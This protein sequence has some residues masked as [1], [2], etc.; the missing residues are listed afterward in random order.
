LF[1]EDDYELQDEENEEPN[2]LI[3]QVEV[4]KVSLQ[5]D[6][7]MSQSLNIFMNSLLKHANGQPFTSSN[8]IHAFVEVV[9]DG[10]AIDGQNERSN[11][12]LKNPKSIADDQIL[13][14]SDQM[15]EFLVTNGLQ[16]IRQKLESEDITLDELVDMKESDFEEVG[17]EKEMRDKLLQISKEVKLSQ[18]SMQQDKLD[19]DEASKIKDKHA[20]ENECDPSIKLKELAPVFS[21][22]AITMNVLEEMDQAALEKIGIRK[23]GHRSNIVLKLK[24]Q[25]T[26][27]VSPSDGTAIY[28][29]SSY[30][31]QCS[32]TGTSQATSWS[33]VRMTIAGGTETPISTGSKYS[34]VNSATAPHLTINNVVE[35]DEQDYY[36]R[37][38]NVAGTQTSTRARLIVNGGELF[39]I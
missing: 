8:E 31:I 34:I 13:Q 12:N 5:S 9:D 14:K 15:N 30:T 23:Y 6:E 24:E 4:E 21:K 7:R 18:S 27:S 29:D 36:C 25:L 33:W 17:I 3:V 35:D 19:T 26:I 22:E 11:E 16:D 37:A 1:E 38:T 32:I 39:V 20:E 28:G 10:R 2:N